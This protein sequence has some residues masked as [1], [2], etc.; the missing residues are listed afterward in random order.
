V[1]GALLAF[2][3]FVCQLMFGLIPSHLTGANFWS[4]A[5]PYGVLLL[6][7]VLWATVQAPVQLDRAS[8]DRIKSLT[9][10]LRQLKSECMEIL[11]EPTFPYDDRRVPGP[12]Q[13]THYRLFRVGIH[14]L[15]SK[16]IDDPEVVVFSITPRPTNMFPPLPLPAMHDRPQQKATRLN[17]N[18]LRYFDVVDQLADGKCR[19][20]QTV[21][22]A[23]NDLPTGQY[24]ITITASGRDVPSTSRQFSISVPPPRMGNQDL[25]FSP[26]SSARSQT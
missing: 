11:F 1:I 24:T 22:G 3:I 13:P 6:V 19:I 16:T 12:S 7:L 15:S 2:G 4:I 9:S 20:V 17:R 25:Q 14:N 21:P 8:K 5:W 18:D 10:E 23:G 26:I